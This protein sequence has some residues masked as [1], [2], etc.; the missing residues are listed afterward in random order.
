MGAAED[1]RAPTEE[2]SYVRGWGL[3]SDETADG[4]DTSSV[5]LERGPDR[6]RTGEAGGIEYSD[7]HQILPND[8]L[9]LKILSH[10]FRPLFI[11]NR[12]VIAGNEV[13]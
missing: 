8:N 7:L 10:T 12:S 9:T 2:L 3:L 11:R 5:L 13:G 4:S 6:S 1:G